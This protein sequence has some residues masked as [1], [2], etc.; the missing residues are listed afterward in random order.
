M[1]IKSETRT[2][3]ATILLISVLCFTNVSARQGP[4]IKRILARRVIRKADVAKERSLQ[5]VLKELKRQELYTKE[6]KKREH[7]DSRKWSERKKEKD[8]GRGVERMREKRKGEPVLRTWSEMFAWAINSTVG[9]DGSD[10]KNHSRILYTASEARIEQRPSTISQHLSTK[11]GEA[12]G[13]KALPASTLRVLKDAKERK[14]AKKQITG[15]RTNSFQNSFR[16]SFEATE[17][18]LDVMIRAVKTINREQSAVNQRVN[19]LLLLEDMCHSID[20]GYDLTL[21]YVGGVS[22]IVH[23]LSD[24]NEQIRATASW[25]LATC[26]MNNGPVQNVSTSLGAVRTLVHLAGEDDNAVVRSRALLALNAVLEDEHAQAEFQKI[27]TAVDVVRKALDDNTDVR[28]V[29][30][31]L[32][33]GELLVRAD[34]SLWKTE[35]EAWDIPIRVERMLTHRDVDIRESAARFI[36][37]MDGGILQ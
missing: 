25:A 2:I 34:L 23:A 1:R 11:K 19:A 29:R 7:R 14:T 5:D 24:E 27:S 36:S 17:S 10:S 28:A 32:N 35:F 16:S 26:A 6:E 8:E 18:P 12:R 37:A 9:R 31:A 15:H 13:V 3:L 4:D 20:N 22:T 33:L 30:R 21:R